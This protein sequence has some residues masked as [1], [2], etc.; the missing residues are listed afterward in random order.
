MK[1]MKSTAKKFVVC[2]KNQGYELSLER[3]K[4]CQ[5][6]SDGEAEKHRQFRVVDESGEDYLYPQRLFAPLELPQTIRRAVLA[7]V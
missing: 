4:I 3:R 5:V 2:L 7:A 1:P 6:L